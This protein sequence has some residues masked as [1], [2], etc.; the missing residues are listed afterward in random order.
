MITLTV[1]LGER[2]YPIL[3]GS[4]LLGRPGLLDAHLS[5]NDVL[6]ITNESVAPIYLEPLKAMLGEA[7]VESLI[8]P[9]GIDLDYV[10]VQNRS[11][12]LCLP[13]EHRR[14]CAVLT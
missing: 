7:R 14:E 8:L 11:G 2:S 6:V 5:G 10:G 13:F 4:G 12:Q 9:D 3:I 1:D